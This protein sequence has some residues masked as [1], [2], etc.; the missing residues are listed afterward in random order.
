[1]ILRRG[2]YSVS[3][4]L[5]VNG[6]PAPAV[7]SV[8]SQTLL[9]VLVN[10][11][12]PAQVTWA[13]GI[14]NG[15][16]ITGTGSIPFMPLS[17]EP[18]YLNVAVLA[19]DG[20]VQ[21]A[22]FPL[23]VTIT[24]ASAAQVM[25]SWANPA[26]TSAGLNSASIQVSGQVVSVA[27]THYLN[28][29]AQDSGTGLSVPV[30]RFQVGVHRLF[31]T[32]IDAQG[33]T[34]VGDSS[35]KV[36][37][38]FGLQA[39][40][41]PPQ[42]FENT[43]VLMGS[44]YSPVFEGDASTATQLPFPVMGYEGSVKLI[45]GSTHFVVDFDPALNVVDDEVVVRTQLGNWT[46]V[47]PPTGLTAEA[48]PYDYQHDQP[49]QPAPLDLSAHYA[50]DAWNIHSV[51]VGAFKFRLRFRCFIA[52]DA[53][54]QYTPCEWSGYSGGLG[55]R[56]RRFIALPSMVDLSLDDETT[57][58]RLNSTGIATFTA[59]EQG[60]ILGNFS[61]T[62]APDQPIYT[63]DHSYTDQNTVAIYES[64]ASLNDLR[65]NALYGTQD[66]RPCVVDFSLRGQPR[67]VNKPKHVYGKL[68]LYVAGGALPAGA[69]VTVQMLTGAAPNAVYVPVTITENVYNP[70]LNGFVLAGAAPIDITDFEFSRL[71]LV[72]NFKVDESNAVAQPPPVDPVMSQAEPF[73]YTTV[74]SPAIR[75]EDACFRNPVLMPVFEG[76]FIGS[77]V[78]LEDCNTLAC[79]PVGTYCYVEVGGTG[80]YQVLQPLGFPAPFVAPI[81]ADTDCYGNPSFMGEYLG[82][83]TDAADAV[84]AYSGTTGCG[85]AYQYNPCAATT[86]QQLA[87]VYPAAAVPHPAISY[88]NS[89]YGLVGLVEDTSRLIGVTASEIT[90][91]AGCLDAVCTGSNPAGGSVDY[92]DQE[93]LDVVTVSFPGLDHG[94]P[95]FGVVPAASAQGWG[96]TP[97]GS[98]KWQVGTAPIYIYTAVENVTLTVDITPTNILR[99]LVLTR[100]LVRQHYRFYAGLGS[101]QIPV[102]AG[103]VLTLEFARTKTYA[104][105]QGQVSWS[106]RVPIPIRYDSV[107]FTLPG[108]TGTLTALGFCGLDSRQDYSFFGILGGPAVAMDL[109]NPDLVTVKDSSSLPEMVLVRTAPAQEPLV[110]VSMPAYAGQQLTSPVVFNFYAARSI[111]GAH[112]EMDVW[113]NT[114]NPAFPPFLTDGPF[115]S[116]A[117]TDGYYRKNTQQSDT[118]RRG[119]T[120]AF[121]D[122]SGTIHSPRI[123]VDERGNN[124][125]VVTTELNDYVYVNGYVYTFTGN[126]DYGISE[127]VYWYPSGGGGP[128]LVAATPYTMPDS[129]QG[130][131]YV[132]STDEVWVAIPN[133]NQVAII[134]GDAQTLKGYISVGNGPFSVAYCPNTDNVAVLLANTGQVQFVDATTHAFQGMAT[135][136]GG[137]FFAEGGN[138]ALIAYNPVSGQVY[139]AGSLSIDDSLPLYEV[140]PVT[141]S[142][143]TYVLASPGPVPRSLYFCPTTSETIISTGSFGSFAFNV[144]TKLWENLGVPLGSSSG[145]CAAPQVARIFFTDDANIGPFNA[146]DPQLLY[147]PRSRLVTRTFQIPHQCV[148]AG[149]HPLRRKFYM[150]AFNITPGQPGIIVEDINGHVLANLPSFGAWA[151]SVYSPLSRLMFFSFPDGVGFYTHMVAAYT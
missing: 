44:V 28:G 65:V 90:P 132:T 22:I 96:L 93:N 53:V 38:P 18:Y 45:P 89:C 61:S 135:L 8:G 117:L 60:F 124:I 32:V 85:I 126:F 63:E 11:A 16:Q 15:P 39:A 9:S 95:F 100:N 84:L 147:D 116:L 137:A 70:G 72:M 59:P 25:V 24:G 81:G 101:A 77:A 46:L 5:T 94:V 73:Y 66:T 125:S 30:S 97:P 99:D 146:T 111:D 57:R 92:F 139:V 123:H 4:L 103:D 3:I 40:V 122:P 134:S 115:K 71:G 142:V 41:V 128:A 91:V 67:I 87:I 120:V 54:F 36:G 127:Q 23:S 149:W 98:V 58:N 49:F 42:P 129:P 27:W 74:N 107:S 131:C 140:D 110:P 108:A 151:N 79:G 86:P 48:L 50:V 83:D 34:A 52:G 76:T 64:T 82:G 33:N 141:L 43:L 29:V 143:A 80:T 6:S 105:I 10:G 47:G 113:L 150:N 2:S 35:I 144:N 19:S 20:T 13:Y 68:L 37:T 145:G 78:P 148:G 88:Q 17:A 31:V 138:P 112:G 104:G 136:G 130:M 62:G 56:E 106:K 55:L 14:R 114:S 7:F 102:Q 75:V 121:D 51:N 109:P 119:L 1:M 21:E 133:T 12:V 69:V 26:P 118:S